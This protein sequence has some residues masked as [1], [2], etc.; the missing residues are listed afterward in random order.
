MQLYKKLYTLM[1]NG[2]Q[3]FKILTLNKFT[4]KIAL[5]ADKFIIGV[6]NYGKCN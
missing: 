1:Y 3:C 4:V 2:I 6:E 5:S